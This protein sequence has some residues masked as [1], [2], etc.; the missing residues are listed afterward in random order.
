[1]KQVVIGIGSNVESRDKRVDEAIV[2]LKS[3][4]T[5]IKTSTAYDTQPEGNALHQYTNAVLEGFTDMSE[6][7]VLALL[8]EYEF[9]NGR[10][11]E[12]KAREFVPIDLDLTIYDGKILR[13]DDFNSLYFTIGY[14]Q[15]K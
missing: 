9:A 1:M 15:I 13:P 5:N 6:S 14:N 10:T 2:F 7:E 11:P 8:K 12:L 4:F 3:R